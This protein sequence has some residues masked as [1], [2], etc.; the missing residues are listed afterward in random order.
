MSDDLEVKKRR[1]WT[2]HQKWSFALAAA[3]LVVSVVAAV[4][5]F[6]LAS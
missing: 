6:Y 5:Q 2:S 4:E 3:G 1:P